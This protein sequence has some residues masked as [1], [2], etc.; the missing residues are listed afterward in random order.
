MI[1]S[2][3]EIKGRGSGKRGK[4][5]MEISVPQAKRILKNTGAKRVSVDAIDEFREVVEEIMNLISTHAYKYLKFEDKTVLLTKHINM[6]IE[7][8]IKKQ[9]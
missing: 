3:S 2:T 6:A 1:L 8:I 5:L 9:E 7:D 4:Q